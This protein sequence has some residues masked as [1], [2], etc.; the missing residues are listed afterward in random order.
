MRH[1]RYKCNTSETRATRA[2]RVLYEQYKCDTSEKFLI[3]ITARVKIYFHI[4]LFTIW[5]VK[6]YK[7][8]NNF[9]LSTTFGNA[10]FP[11]QNAFDCTKMPLIAKIAPQKLKFVMVKAISKSYMLDC[12]CKFPCTFPHSYT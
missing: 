8:R 9:I 10:S 2:T 3:L 11:C 6:D 7:E 12:N 4:P 1:E 5:Q